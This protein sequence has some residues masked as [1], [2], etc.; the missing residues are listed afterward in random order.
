[1]LR[2]TDITLG[3]PLRGSFTCVRYPG[4]LSRAKAA[5]TVGK[6]GRTGKLTAHDRFHKQTVFVL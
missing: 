4:W 6:A 2:M 3:L 1:M 5:L